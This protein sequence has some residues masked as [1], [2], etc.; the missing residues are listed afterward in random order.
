MPFEMSMGMSLS[1]SLRQEQRLEQRIYLAQRLEL[2]QALTLRQAIIPIRLRALSQELTDNFNFTY[3]EEDEE[4]LDAL[5]SVKDRKKLIS[6]LKT[7]GSVYTFD[8]ASVQAVRKIGRLFDKEDDERLSFDYATLILTYDLMEKSELCPIPRKK[9]VSEVYR[10]AKDRLMVEIADE[11]GFEIKKGEVNSAVSWDYLKIPR[12]IKGVEDFED[13][14][15]L[16]DV[17]KHTMIGDFRAF[18]EGDNDY[19][20]HNR[21]VLEKLSNLGIATEKWRDYPARDSFLL[22][23]DDVFDLSWDEVY[24]NTK[25]Q[26]LKAVGQRSKG[27]EGYLAGKNAG[28]LFSQL[29]ENLGKNPLDIA[30]PDDVRIAL[31]T[32][33]QYVESQSSEEAQRSLTDVRKL[34][35]RVQLNYTRGEGGLVEVA[36]WKRDPATD[37][38]QGNYTHCCVA[39]DGQYSDAILDYLTNYSFNLAEVRCNNRIIGQAYLVATQDTDSGKPVLLVDNVEVNNDYSGRQG[40]EQRV[41]NYV[42]NLGR[43]L[44][45]SEVVTGENY[46]DISI[47][48]LPRVQRNLKIIG[49]LPESEESLYVDTF[50]GW[51]SVEGKVD[52]RKIS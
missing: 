7:H 45:F 5:N 35:K 10:K 24:Q 3:Y 46:Q 33:N 14:G 49:G 19:G 37:M 13:T 27:I 11:V 15:K 48:G 23:G 38:F 6:F 51:S 30:E 50:G 4:Y 20:R 18:I 32:I 21:S 12:L 39:I 47:Q 29:K 41:L 9:P 52:V 25:E 31:E 26:I 8:G 16:E 1:Q 28:K 34:L 44:G 22:E 36:S 2:S 40:L 42:S 43:E 17:V